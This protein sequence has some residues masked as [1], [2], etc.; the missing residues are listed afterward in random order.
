MPAKIIFGIIKMFFNEK[1]PLSFFKTACI[2]KHFFKYT[3]FLL[4]LNSKGD[5]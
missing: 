2:I 4:I 1:I 3:F 5:I